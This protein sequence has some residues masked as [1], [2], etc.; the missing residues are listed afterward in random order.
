MGNC[1]PIIP[2]DMNMISYFLQSSFNAKTFN[3][4]FALSRPSFPVQA[5]A[6]PEL[7][8][9]YFGFDLD[10]FFFEIIIGAAANLLRVDIISVLLLSDKQINNPSVLFFFIPSCNV[11]NLDFIKVFH[12]I[13]Y[14]SYLLQGIAY[15]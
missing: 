10:I 11:I 6:L 13:V 9:I 1:L 2:V 3:I 12:S 4:A 15:F 14:I 7:I 8:K 5:L